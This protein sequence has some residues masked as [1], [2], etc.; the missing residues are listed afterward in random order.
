M[1]FLKNELKNV[2][3]P[4]VY[5]YAD[6]WFYWIAYISVSSVFVRITSDFLREREKLPSE[7]HLVNVDILIVI[8]RSKFDVFF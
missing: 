7:I 2:D 6:R 3:F 5:S 8:F 1:M 4:S